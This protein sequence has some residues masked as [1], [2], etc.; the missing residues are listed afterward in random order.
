M[1]SENTTYLPPDNVTIKDKA[2]YVVQPEVLTG[3]G[4][5]ACAPPVQAP[6]D[7][8]AF[9]LRIEESPAAESTPD[10]GA[11]ERLAAGNFPRD[12]P[13]GSLTA[14][15]RDAVREIAAM[16]GQSAGIAPS[17]LPALVKARLV[18]ARAMSEALSDISDNIL[19]LPAGFELAKIPAVLRE[20]L[21][22]NRESRMMYAASD[23]IAALPGA[24]PPATSAAVIRSAAPAVELLER[25]VAEL[26]AIRGVLERFNDADLG[27][28]K[29]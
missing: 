20:R 3:A 11:V 16:I 4:W 8:L 26:V 28:L 18:N 15:Y 12:F 10:P 7:A 27:R 9:R 6:H 5:D 14:S 19:D 2:A 22:D 23:L 29:E 13:E 25:I 1:P 21:G 17:D 24:P